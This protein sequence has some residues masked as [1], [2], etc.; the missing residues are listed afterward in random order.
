MCKC[1]SSLLLVSSFDVHLPNSNECEKKSEGQRQRRGIMEQGNERD[2]ESRM[3]ICITLKSI[4]AKVQHNCCV[5]V[6][7]FVIQFF[8][9][10]VTPF[11]CERILFSVWLQT[12][13]VVMLTLCAQ[14]YIILRNCSVCL[15]VSM[16]AMCNVCCTLL[17]FVPLAVRLRA[18]VIWGIAVGSFHFFLSLS[19]PMDG[20]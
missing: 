6:R 13:N 9:F 1:N 19:F 11:L 8:P 17:I 12:V 10:V 7:A 14:Y 20:P 4:S 3:H 5:C 18:Y 15:C 16:C 2:T